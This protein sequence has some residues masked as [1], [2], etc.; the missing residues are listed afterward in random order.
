MRVLV[1][2]C[3]LLSLLFSSIAAHA[4]FVVKNIRIEG[5]QGISPDTVMT[6]IPIHL[7]QTLQ[8]ADSAKI[9]NALYQTGFFSNVSL[10]QQGNV[11]VVNVVERPIITSISNE[12][13]KS[14]DKDKLNDTIK[15]LGL[16]AG[17]VLDTSVLDRVKSSLETQYDSIGKYN[18]HV[19]TI[20]TPLS[21]NRVNVKIVISEGR[22]AEVQQIHIIGN[23]AFSTERLLYE[24]PLT[25]PR[26]WDLMTGGDKYSQDKLNTA[27]D[28]LRSYYMDR[29]YLKFK[30]DSTQA[31]LTPDRNYVYIII[32][33]TEGPIY[34]LKGYQVVGN[35]VI[36]PATLQ[37]I[38]TIHAGETFSQGAVK[39]SAT[40][41]SR[42]LGNMGFAFATVQP[43]P[44]V[45]EANKAV[46]ITYYVQPG[47]R[48]SV[49]RINFSGNT[50]TEDVVLRRNMPQMEGGLVSVDD[51]KESEHQLNLLGYESD[52]NVQ[53]V[54]VPNVPDQVDLDYSVTEAPSAQATVGVGYGTDGFQLNAG[55]NQSNFMGTG[56]TVGF[57]ASAS[58][59][60]NS[61]N[62]N[63][64]NPYYTN[65]GISRGFSLYADRVTPGNLH[66]A[67]YTSNMYGGAVNYSIPLSAK[68]DSLQL[69]Y[70]Y[71]ITSLFLGTSHD[72]PS[73]QLLNFVANNGRHFD[74]V[75]LTGGWTRNDLDRT[76]LPTSGLY[77][78]LG[79][80]VSLPGGSNA[81]D[82]YKTNYNFSFY[83]PLIPGYIL[84]ARGD[85]GYGNGFAGTHGLPFFANYYAGGPEGASDGWVRGF[86][87]NTLGPRDSNRDPLGG[88]I[89]T[90]G[91][92][93]LIFPNP[94]GEDKLRT[95]A[96]LD[97][98]NVY[99]TLPVSLGGGAPPLGGGV[100][101]PLRLSAGIA[102]DW[103]VP[104]LNVIL[105]VSV[106]EPLNRQAHDHINRVQFNLGTNF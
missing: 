89:L 76:T 17:Q 18:A 104:V 38:I 51:I 98:G 35:T 44:D 53:T 84:M 27:L 9:I 99:T 103:R 3:L 92:L 94:V 49:R 106:A 42:T 93:G 25:S 86:Q 81:L 101:G 14:L 58:R 30:I 2:V 1:K 85:L 50:K 5:L 37:K 21:R 4:A 65:D 40:A 80:E 83:Q 54:P 88:N 31:T 74:Q 87:T 64:N 55:V 69:G 13:N 45:D 32:H 39:D 46:F 12:G 43:V 91:T 6:Y 97:G 7:G 102:A 61:Y 67:P 41:I 70:G 105:D 62:F 59:Y 79:A 68:G 82:Y 56:K 24:L 60:I 10:A 28:A 90:S 15:N 72:K 66:I 34:K 29:G 26:P 95:T 78:A 71:Q 47:T 11:L 75:L 48:V 20:V 96:F 73:V 23:Q 8:P 33:I 100:A 22:T 16:V 57:N 36:A 52:V 19:D 77:Q 63:Y